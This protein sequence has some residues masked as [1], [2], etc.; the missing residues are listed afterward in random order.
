MFLY[1][2]IN[3]LNKENVKF[4]VAGGYALA[5]HGIVRAT[6]DVDLCIKL[7]KKQFKSIEKAL[8]LIGLKSRLPI[9]SDDMALYRKEYIENRNLTAWSFVDYKNPAR[10]VDILI[11]E[12][13]KS[14]DYETIIVSGS[15]VPVLKLE[16]LYD[17]K[18]ST[19]RAKD[20]E[21]LQ[22][23]LKKIKEK[24]VRN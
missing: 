10:I 17:M 13:L 22:P 16:K 4:A 6:I 21:D 1:D 2:V 3:I 19:G 24:K 8:S 20:K 15:K 14:S 7:S 5:L 11:T 18:Q 9:S 23:I 12:D